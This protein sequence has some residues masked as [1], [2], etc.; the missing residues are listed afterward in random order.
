[1]PGALPPFS[2]FF[3]QTGK[4]K[5]PASEGLEIDPH[6]PMFQKTET[7]SERDQDGNQE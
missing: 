3:L 6:D 5:Q 7:S 2:L 4:K 1:L